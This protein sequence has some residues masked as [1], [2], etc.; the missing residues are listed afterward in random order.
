MN[1]C[2]IETSLRAG[3]K[4][5][6]QPLALAPSAAPIPLSTRMVVSALGGMGA[7]TCCHPIDVVRIQMQ[8]YNFKNSVD[9]VKQIVAKSGPGSL[10][11]GIT[12]A[13][14]RQWT[15]GSCRMGIYS[16]LLEKVTKGLQPG[17]QV[18]FLQKLGMGCVSGGIGSFVGNPAE[19]SMVRMSADSRLPELERRNYKNVGECIVRVARTEGAGALWTGATPTVIRAMLLSST[20]LAVYSECKEALPKHFPILQGSPMGTMFCG[21]LVC[22]FLANVICTPFD[23]VKSRLQQMPTPAPGQPPLYTGM[24]D[25]FSKGVAAEGPSVLFRGFTPAFL[26]LAPYTCISF[27]LTEKIMKAVTGKEAF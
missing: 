27:V 10:Y 8:L 14:L 16:F 7:A 9:A 23:V 11:N 6:P 5:S 15:Y 13:Y 25:C 20:T 24:V 17:E 3:N 4:Q 12:A 19:L 26:K 18:S 21:S 1:N 22:S 2:R